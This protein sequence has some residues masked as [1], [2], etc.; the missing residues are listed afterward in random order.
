MPYADVVQAALYDPDHGFYA[1]GG[2]AGRRGDFLTSPEVGP[3]FGHLVA[4]A[5]DAEWD[6]L[7]QPDEFMFVDYG[8]GPGTLARAV[9]ASPPRCVDR[10]RYV[11]VER[12]AIQRADHPPGVISLEELTS[13]HFGAG[14]T[15]IIFAN[16]LLDNFVF[17]P[18]RWSGSE[19]TF[20]K[21]QLG[22]D[23]QLVEEFVSQPD[24]DTTHLLE[25][26][27]VVD[28][29]Q[30]GM[31]VKQMT[32]EVL[33]AGRVIVIDY[34]RLDTSEVEVRTYAEHGR[35]GDPLL[36][37]GTKDITVD[38]DL[39]ALQRFVG[40]ATSVSPQHVWLRQ[41][42]LDDFVDEGRE[43]WEREA[44]VGGLEA[45]RAKSRIREADSLCDPSG[46]GG[47]FVSEWV[48]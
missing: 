20:A 15:G 42:G 46:L 30:A 16:E 3:L 1:S 31:W 22:S 35:Q 32:T 28:Q 26:R 47:F 14:L 9:F 11:A 44:A 36:A 12:S 45:L 8:A 40:P 41:H 4:R 43:I 10:L 13:E 6:R 25:Q 18:I 38:V 34:A 21:V 39:E 7:G 24:R 19:A 27:S 33:A 48:L 5:I 2:R 29:T 23:D 17:T 37:L